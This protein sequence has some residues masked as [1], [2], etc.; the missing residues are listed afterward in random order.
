MVTSIKTQLTP[1]VDVDA[2][3][4]IHII[5]A[6]VSR[7]KELYEAFFDDNDKKLF[8]ERLV[9]YAIG[10]LYDSDGVDSVPLIMCNAFNITLIVVDESEKRV[11]DVLP[12][13]SPDGRLP[14]TSVILHK[15]GDHY[16]GVTPRVPE[17]SWRVGR[18][19]FYDKC[20]RSDQ[21][22]DDKTGDNWT[23]VKMTLMILWSPWGNSVE[24]TP[25]I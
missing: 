21:R 14:Y 4:L 19:Q 1:F 10:K 7:N 16:N 23:H 13:F 12:T 5:F 15:V 8:R 17:K 3:D 24:I 9:K 25:K 22:S 2:N 18:A 11:F 6:E 20:D